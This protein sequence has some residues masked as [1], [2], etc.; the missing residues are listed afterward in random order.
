MITVNMSNYEYI[1]TF[2]KFI[3]YISFYLICQYI[4][5]HHNMKTTVIHLVFHYEKDA[6]ACT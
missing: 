4:A 2:V 1:Y 5:V 6:V 3:T